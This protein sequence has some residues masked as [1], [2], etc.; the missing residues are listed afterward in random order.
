MAISAVPTAWLVTPLSD[1]QARI[2]GWL[3]SRTIMSR[4][5]SVLSVTSSAAGVLNP[6]SPSPL[7]WTIMTPAAAAGDEQR[8]VAPLLLLGDRRPQ[9]GVVVA[10]RAAPQEHRVPVE[11]RQVLVPREGPDA[12]GG[13]GRVDH[14]AVDADH[15]EHLVEGGPPERAVV[16]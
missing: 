3:R 11:E 13:L 8:E 2:D 12:E 10:A 5:S 7:G 1:S 4:C 6:F 9:P 16:R 14:R 15:V